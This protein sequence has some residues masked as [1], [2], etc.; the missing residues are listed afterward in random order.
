[1]PNE[2]NI[3]DFKTKTVN[4]SRFERRISELRRQGKY[5]DNIKKTVWAAINNVIDSK[6]KSF[7]IYGEPQSGKT[8]LMISLTAKLLDEGCKI[9]IILVN[10]NIELLDQNLERFSRSG[11][12]PSPKNFTEILDPS[13][14]V[15][16]G[17]WIVFCKK[18]SQNL[19]NLNIKFYN[20]RNKIIIDDEADYATPNSKINK[21]EKTKINELV[22]ELLG[23]NGCYIGVTATP[24][25]LDLND[26]FSN[27]SD[28]WL[29]FE[30]HPDYTGQDVF[31]PTS[32]ESIERQKDEF[33]LF[34]LSDQGDDPRYLREAIFRFLINVAYINTEVNKQEEEYSILIHTSGSKADHTED[35]KTVVKVLSILKNR[36]TSKFD[37]YVKNIWQM[38][39]E[40][41]PGFEEK[42]TRYITDNISRN[43]IIVINS[44]KTGDTKKATSPAALFTFAI[45]GNIIS[46]GVTFDN[47]L[48]M[49]FT[50]DSKQKIQQDTYIQRARMFGSRKKYLKY[51]ELTIPAKLYNEWQKCFVFHKLSL[52]A[53]VS[54]KGSPIWLEDFR[55]SSVA[56]NS[57]HYTKV[58]MESGEMGFNK[59][60]YTDEIEKVVVNHDNAISKLNQLHDV[61]GDSGFP[62]YL[63]NFIVAFIP[64]NDDSIALHTTR[65]IG[66][67]TSYHDTLDRPRGFFGSQDT[68]KY[69][70]AIHHIMIHKNTKGIARLIYKYSGT[71]KT[72]R[73]KK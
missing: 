15:T 33:L 17:E 16:C 69:P 9:I 13:I 52:N 50:R 10:D 2:F 19:K 5:T 11:L 62:K 58:D 4:R 42:L 68:N 31:F 63:I 25:R 6:C 20:C 51:F 40:K 48:S 14:D 39:K 34:P 72:I 37:T 36:E 45:G 60:E 12:D 1:M 70:M 29:C 23:S 22:E 32:I 61:I 28:R 27:D 3:E 57:I 41:Y 26:T 18:N 8:E 30:P 73:R 65:E 59:F 56:R 55:I 54:G 7:V 35:Y 67:E 47:L 21:G 66:V 64:N 46:R 43:T 49:F 38:C 71:L 44:D 53:I 24:A